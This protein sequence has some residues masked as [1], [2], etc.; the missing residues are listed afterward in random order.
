MKLIYVAGKFRARDGWDLAGNIRQA[1]AA[2]MR[3]ALAGAVPVCVHSMFA[4]FDRTL[5]D[6]FWID[7]TMQI[8]RRCNAVW[9]YDVHHLDS[10]EGTRG[11]RDHADWLGMPVFIG[12]L[13]FAEMVR[14]L[15]GGPT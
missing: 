9:I 1:E 4:A 14:W 13:G 15:D 8:M 10:S 3:V 12:E 6:R 11:E 5:T 2:A 7:A